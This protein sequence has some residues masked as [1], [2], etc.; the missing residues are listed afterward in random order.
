MTEVGRSQLCLPLRRAIAHRVVAVAS[1]VLLAVDAAVHAGDAAYY[2]ANTGALVSQGILFRIEAVVALVL[3]I[4]LLVRP[5]RV[6]WMAALATAASAAGAVVLSTYVDLG[7]LGPLPDLYEPTWA[8]PGKLPSAIAETLAAVFCI[9][10]LALLPRR[11]RH[12]S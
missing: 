6:V 11:S 7:V 2:D 4:A 10:G 1:A 3:A 8:T 12:V 5:R 9:A